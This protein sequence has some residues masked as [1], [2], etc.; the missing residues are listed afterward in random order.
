[1]SGMELHQILMQMTCIGQ[2]PTENLRLRITNWLLI[3]TYHGEIDS[4]INDTFKIIRSDANWWPSSRISIE[5][6]KLWDHIATTTYVRDSLRITSL[7]LDF[8]KLL[9]WVNHTE[10]SAFLEDV[11]ILGIVCSHCSQKLSWIEILWMTLDLITHSV[12]LISSSRM[13]NSPM[14]FSRCAFFW[15]L[16]FTS[17]RYTH[18]S[19]SHFVIP[20]F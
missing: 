20:E 14:R 3:G 7:I 2:R 17:S 11:L 19:F 4:T 1:M 8:D 13:S 15:F 18:R 5:L 16:D 12:H 10:H 6:D 9:N